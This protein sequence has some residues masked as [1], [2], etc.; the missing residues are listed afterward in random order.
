MEQGL[1]DLFASPGDIVTDRDLRLD[2]F[3]GLALFCMF[4]DHIPDNFVAWFTFQAFMSCDA[5][6]VFVFISG[7][8]AGLVYSRTMERHGFLS[9]GIR[10]LQ[11]VWQIYVAHILIFVALMAALAL[12]SHVLNTW[13][14][15]DYHQGTQA[16]LMEPGLALMR[17]LTLQFQ[18]L[19]YTD[20]LPL[21][22]V[23]LAILPLALAGFRFRPIVVIVV[24]LSV[25]LSIQL[26]PNVAFTAWPDPREGWG[27][28]PLAWQALYVLAAWLAWRSKDLKVSTVNRRWWVYV[29]G[30]CV[31][32]G[33]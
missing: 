32:A 15:I 19:S 23:C 30:V 28:N 25:W 6:E 18:S 9:G 16:F 20:I 12:T 17:I 21:Y 10:V 24:F 11:R 26:N 2:F 29:A 7:F 27:F 33:L 1:W 5:T 22:I 31:V 4:I 3:R 13:R 14:Y 8:T